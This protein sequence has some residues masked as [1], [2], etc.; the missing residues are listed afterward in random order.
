MNVLFIGQIVPEENIQCT[1]YSAAGDNFQKN[2][3][4]S[5]LYQGEEVTILSVLP[6]ASFPK[7]RVYVKGKQ[8]F[9]NNHSVTEIGYINI[10]VLKQINQKNSLI[11][12]AK[13]INKS[14]KIDL[15]MSFNMYSQ[16][17][18]SALYLKKIL[19]VPLVPILADLPI[20]S[21]TAYSGL[22]KFVFPMIKRNTFKRIRQL[23]HCI[24]LNENVR[25]YLNSNCTS[26]IIP[27]GVDET[28]EQFEYKE[29]TE[30]NIIY[31][32]ALTEY[33]GI[34]NLMDAVA[35]LGNEYVL[36]IYGS[37]ELS[38]FVKEISSNIGNI[39]Y[40]GVLPIEQM[41]EKMK[42]AWVLVNPR[43]TDDPI[44]SV[45]F[46][47]KLFEYVMCKRPVITTKFNGMPND[48]LN[49]VW[50]CGSG[51]VDEI[52]SA[53]ISINESTNFEIKKKV[54]NA[55]E[56]IFERYNWNRIGEDIEHY[57]NHIK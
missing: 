31:A 34:R 2:I 55:Y 49:I 53:L 20:E 52:M 22:Y 15:I 30:K 1:G 4:R 33:S 6:N 16:F 10:T 39:Q 8:C 28:S 41:R 50:S 19:G 3:I 21:A 56:Y 46:P 7:D 37:G 12:A 17:G 32:G 35:Q 40:C 5:L 23:Q 43:S 38:P 47:S 45:S 29:V 13:R 51:S 26:L 27:G 54:E 25:G 44:S 24:I 48:I 9:W 14:R 11:R 57:L 42:S 18:E 36:K